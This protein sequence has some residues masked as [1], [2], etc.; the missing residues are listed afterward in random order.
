MQD[1]RSPYEILG[2]AETATER[3]IKRRYRE[4]ARQ[5]HP[6]VSEEKAHAHER[7]VAIAEAYR[8][9][10]DPE[11]RAKVDAALREAPRR[12]AGWRPE[13]V[14]GPLARARLRFE[15]GDYEEALLLCAEALE[16][17]PEDAEVHRLVAQVYQ[18]QGREGLA[19]RAFARARRLGGE[20][21]GAE[22]PEARPTVAEDQRE[23]PEVPP[24]SPTKLRLGTL[25][26]GW[27]G[28]VALSA[29]VWLAE[30][31]RHP[32]GVNWATAVAT[33]GGAALLGAVLA[34]HGWLGS[35]DDELGGE[36]FGPGRSLM[37][38][39]ALVVVASILAAP[40]GLVAALLAG[41]LAE[42]FLR[43]TVIATGAA[44]C[45]VG[46]VGVAVHLRGMELLALCRPGAGLG[47]FAVVAAL[48]GWA[49]GGIFRPH[50]WE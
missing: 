22:A 34:G 8:V 5:W 31:G 25:G 39:G 15:E 14:L 27:A 19:R 30:P 13:P 9:L 33:I 12:R 49:L 47:G 50:V 11:T 16:K 6:D 21:P 48:A 40:L 18:A 4:L 42:R 7:F 28:L 44:V 46:L 3:Q 35:F 36:V 45:W 29:V 2:I 20:M 37:P 24:Y 10:S 41:T 23:P 38:I 26:L 43:G 1:G 17:T 32:M